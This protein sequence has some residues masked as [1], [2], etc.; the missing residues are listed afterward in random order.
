MSQPD[1]MGD[2]MRDLIRVIGRELYGW[3]DDEPNEATG[4]IAFIEVATIAAAVYGAGYRRT[5]RVSED[6]QHG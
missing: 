6:E 4:H 5:P 1:G 3:A 2:T